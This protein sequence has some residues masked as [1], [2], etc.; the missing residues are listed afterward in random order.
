VIFEAKALLFDNDGVLVDSHEAVVD[1]WAKFGEYYRLQGFDIRNH[2]GTRAQD[3]VLELLGTD[4][5][6]EANNLIN[7]F[8][9][10]TAHET[11]ALPGARELLQSLEEVQWTICT[12]ANPNLGRARIQAAGLPL[13]EQLVTAADV[14]NGKPAPDPYLLGAKRLG[15]SARD[16]VVFEDAV[17]GVQAARAA[18][19]GLVV[20]V[21]LA[22][23]ATEAD[24][25]V[26]DLTGISFDGKQLVIQ[27]D[28]IL[29]DRR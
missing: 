18:G 7:A 23:L 20:G 11:V 29:E 27:D 10:E 2:L 21:S 13:P 25:V 5:F 19:V 8:E 16:C 9:Q 4:R 28:K 15:V 12:S 6:E 17:A 1:A 22:A 26:L 14:E 3:L 24:L